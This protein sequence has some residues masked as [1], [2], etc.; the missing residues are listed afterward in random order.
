ML[1]N[2]K[3][4]QGFLVEFEGRGGRRGENPLYKLRRK[5]PVGRGKFTG[6]YKF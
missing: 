1:L 2:N 4:G 6:M 5:L 3:K